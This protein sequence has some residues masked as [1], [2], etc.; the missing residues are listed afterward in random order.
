MP[1]YEGKEPG[2]RLVGDSEYE[3][4][5]RRLNAYGYTV[6]SAFMDAQVVQGLKRLVDSCWQ[7]VCHE[8]YRGR[9]ERDV[10]DKVVYNLQNKNKVFID[11]L[12][13]SFVQRLCMEKLNDRYY[14][15]I[16]P[17]KPNYILSYYNA[18]SS[19]SKLDLHIDSYVP[20]PG[21]WCTAIQ[22][23]FLLDDANESNGCTVVVPGSHRSGEYTDRGLE[24]LVPVIA[25]A[26]DIVIWDSRLWHGTTENA[27]GASRWA[28]IATMTQWWVKQ[29]MDIPRSL[30]E[31]IYLQL[32]DEQK[33]LLGFCAIP[34][35]DER[36]RIN[37]KCGYDFLKPSVADYF[38]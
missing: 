38:R 37:T 23:S 4:H 9:P 29:S 2:L 30:P 17:E 18:R 26:G 5:L 28:L 31:E 25:R 20:N 11:L 7:G 3:Q 19:G 15:F 35:R 24:D 21:P 10:Q 27:T 16:L 32:S 13:C 22:I 6:V 8:Q 1:G 34:P 36:E 12:V 33:A 14:R